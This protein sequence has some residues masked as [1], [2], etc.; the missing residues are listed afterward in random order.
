MHELTITGLSSPQPPH[1]LAARIAERWR[2]WRQRRRWISELQ[3][4]A[5]LGRLDDLLGDI[6]ISH[7]DL[8]QLIDRPADA[9]RQFEQLAA[10]EQVDLRQFPPEV[11]REAEWACLRCECR[12]PCKRWLRTGAWEHDGDSRCPNAALLHH[13]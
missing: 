4:V 13:H 8:D 12:A 2:L 11:L 9:G 1:S 10:M 3:Q 7:A 6:G 5:A